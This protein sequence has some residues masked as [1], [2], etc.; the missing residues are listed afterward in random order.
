[1]KNVDSYARLLQ[2]FYGYYKPIYDALDK[3]LSNEIVPGYS[4]RR[5]PEMILNDASYFSVITDKTICSEIPAITNIS[6]AM[7][8]FYVLEG[9]TM[10]GS[11]IS[12]KIS[13]NLK[14]DHDEGLSFF[15]GYGEMNKQM[16]NSFLVSLNERSHSFNKLELIYTAGKTFS[17]FRNWIIYCYAAKSTVTY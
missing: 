11:I 15:N 4:V 5:K 2:C 7:G 8:A 1:M 10:G 6:Q 12:K 9:S 13:E 16:W 17:Q 3:Y 14:I